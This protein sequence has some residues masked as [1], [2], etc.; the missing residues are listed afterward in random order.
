MTADPLALGT[1]GVINSQTVYGET[2]FLDAFSMA[3]LELFSLCVACI[4]DRGPFF[5]HRLPFFDDFFL[6]SRADKLIWRHFWFLSGD[7]R[8]GGSFDDQGS[9]GGGG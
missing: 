7:D 6:E 8:R 5:S 2:K 1:A 4:N 9:R 3:S